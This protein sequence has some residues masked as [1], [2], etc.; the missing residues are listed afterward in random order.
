MEGN[1]AGIAFDRRHQKIIVSDSHNHRL[2]YFNRADLKH[3]S[4]VGNQGNQKGQF[5]YPSGLCIQPSTNKL[6]VCDLCNHRVQVLSDQQNE[7]FRRIKTHV[8]KYMCRE[9]GH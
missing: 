2:Q 3:L 5:N 4:S 1:T 9:K 6:L 7:K 8:K